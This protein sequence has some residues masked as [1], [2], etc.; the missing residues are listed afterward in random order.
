M[1][2]AIDDADPQGPYAFVTVM[3]GVNSQYRGRDVEDYRVEFGALLLR[4][5]VLAGGDQ[6]R[7]VVL[8]IPDWSVTPFAEGRDRVKI[9]A[10]IAL[11][12]DANRNEARRIGVKYV[13]ITPISREA[14]TDARFL[15]DDLLHPS[16]KMY[17]AWTNLIL[18]EAHAIL[19]SQG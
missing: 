3:V 15:A 13:D 18:P 17:A 9:S 11:F 6:S 16:G 8:S 12:N 5:V 2:L 19:K 10:E 7:V 4:A 14:E 1:S